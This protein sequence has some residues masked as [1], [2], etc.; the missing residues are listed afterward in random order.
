MTENL[1]NSFDSADV[2]VSITYFCHILSQDFYTG[3]Y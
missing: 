3:H 2:R 1:K